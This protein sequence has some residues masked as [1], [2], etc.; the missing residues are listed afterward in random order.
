M[1]SSI[2]EVIITGSASGFPSPDRAG[3]SFLLNI[4]SKLYQFDAGE[5]FASSIVK[6]SIDHSKIGT[7]II[8]HAHADHLVGL[9]MEIQLMHLAK[10]SERL[11][12]YVPDE[13]KSAVEQFWVATYLFKERIGFE[14]ELKSIQ[15]DPVFRD[16]NI[17]VYARPNSHLDGYKSTID[18]GGYPHKMQSYSYV[19]KTAKKRIIYSGDVGSLTDYADLLPECDWLITE[20]L[21]LD[22]EKLFEAAGQNKVE[23]LL[24][25]HLSDK[26]Y[27]NPE[28]IR[29]LAAKYGVANIHIANDGFR[30]RI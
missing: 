8:S 6:Q 22:Q 2:V 5:G 4:N 7:I 10:R 28:H 14:I 11:V 1:T 17:T 27:R 3:S 24:L 13:A 23:H 16:E 18:D 12:I 26:T 19:I 9:F 20:G 15:P 29:E 25:T 30:L 21:H